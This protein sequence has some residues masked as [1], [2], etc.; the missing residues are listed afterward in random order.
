MF[1]PGNLGRLDTGAMELR[2]CRRTGG[3]LS[4]IDLTE[5]NTDKMNHIHFPWCRLILI[6]SDVL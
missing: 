2:T 6:L 1:I 3:Y 5:R 4:S